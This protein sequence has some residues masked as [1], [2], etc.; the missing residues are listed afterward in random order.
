MDRFE[1][2]MRRRTGSAVTRSQ[3][4]SLGQVGVK[5]NSRRVK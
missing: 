1:G 2:G 4:Q 3:D 5:S